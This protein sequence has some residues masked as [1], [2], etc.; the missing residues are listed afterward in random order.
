V[1]DA[2]VASLVE[3]FGERRAMED[4]RA[5]LEDLAADAA[6]RADPLPSTA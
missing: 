2:W 5:A 6:S 3:R 1:P 4:A